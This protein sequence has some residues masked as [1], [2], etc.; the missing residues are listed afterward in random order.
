MLEP[1]EADILRDCLTWLKLHGVF[2]WRQN[3]GAI[4]GEYNGKRRFLRFSSAPRHQRHRRHPAA[5]G[6]APGHRVQASRS[7]A[8]AGAG[9]FSPGGPPGRRR[10]CLHSQSGRIGAGAAWQRLLAAQSSGL[11]TRNAA[12]PGCLP[13]TSQRNY[14]PLPRSNAGAARDL[15]TALSPPS[16]LSI[17]LSSLRR[18]SPEV[19]SVARGLRMCFTT[20][21]T[22][23]LSPGQDKTSSH[24]LVILPDLRAEV[25]RRLHGRLPRIP[26]P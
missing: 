12:R 14:A 15:A 18:E 4:A 2:C 26:L 16:S 3:Q 19:G 20:K 11:V 13:Q 22:G 10:G 24:R 5:G 17:V 6:P 25:L 8:H 9:A 23:G 21:N 7:Q 1:K